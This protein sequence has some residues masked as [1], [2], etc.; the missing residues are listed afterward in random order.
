MAILH[1]KPT[2]YRLRCEGCGKTF[3][4]SGYRLYCDACGNS[5]LLR[6][7][8]LAPLSLS[9]APDRFHSY[10]SAIPCIPSVPGWNPRM[11]AFAAP[12]L[13]AELGLDDLWVLLSGNAPEHGAEFATCSFKE[14]EAVGVLARVAAQTDKMLVVSSAGNAARS[15]LDVTLRTGQPAIVVVPRRAV[16]MMRVQS[17]GG[18]Q[19]PLLIA[20]DDASYSDAIDAVS[21]LVGAFPDRLIREGGCFNVARR[22]CMGIPFLSAATR[23]GRLP[24]WYVQAV[25]SGTGAISAW[26]GAARLTAA[27][28]VA[29]S[30]MRLLLVQNHPFTP[31]AE[32]WAA[33]HKVTAPMAPEEVRD[34]LSQVAASVLSNSTPPYAVRGGIHD[35]LTASKGDMVSVLNDEIGKARDLVRARLG[36]A[37]CPASGAAMAGLAKAAKQGKVGRKDRILLHMTGTDPAAAGGKLYAP[38]LVVARGDMQTLIRA[39]DGY[40]LRA[41]A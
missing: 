39:I 10:D 19:K 5:A 6:T 26:E 2:H 34:K 25:G 40:L 31:M 12:E 22:D 32:A 3:S 36:A 33:G 18:R 20:I 16:E 37:I 21:V 24:D 38:D 11:A 9:G 4:E 7:E 14:A 30:D 8:Y 23:M 29:K 13:G 35:I 41:V 1:A 15:F 17:A 28:I 27:G